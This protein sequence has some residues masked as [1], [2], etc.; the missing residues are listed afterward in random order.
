MEFFIQQNT[1][2]PILKMDVVRDCRTDSW[3]DF[4]SV[5]DNASISF[6]MK[7]TETGIQKIFM[8]DAHITEK[9]RA[10]QDST[11]EYYIYYKW[12]I[13]DT[14]IKGRFVGEFLIELETGDL[15]VPIRENLYINII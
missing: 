6:S 10:N 3:K 15:I 13:K 2:L 1:T 14:N 7:N 12:D 9:V 8:K 5:L 11:I 4:Y